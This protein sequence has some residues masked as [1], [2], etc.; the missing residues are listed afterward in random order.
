MT[1]GAESVSGRPGVQVQS[2][3]TAQPQRHIGAHPPA[4]GALPLPGA[5]WCRAPGSSGTL[6]LTVAPVVVAVYMATVDV[7]PGLLLVNNLTLGQTGEGQGV[8]AHRTLRAGGIQLLA[9]GLQLFEGG[10]VAQSGGSPP[11]QGGPTQIN[12]RTVLEG[13]GLIFN[14]KRRT[15][16][17]NVAGKEKRGEKRIHQLSSLECHK[18]GQR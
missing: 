11:Q 18:Q 14:L 2:S 16:D 12:Q 3:L 6:L 9:K 5:G 10:G 8:E 13:I 1:T 15:E 4:H 17:G 7:D